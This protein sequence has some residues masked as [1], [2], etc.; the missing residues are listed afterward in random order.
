MACVILL[1]IS[2]AI[3]VLVRTLCSITVPHIHYCVFLRRRIWPMEK[4]CVNISR[5]YQLLC[6]SFEPF[7]MHSKSMWKDEFL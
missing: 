1:L 4:I 3:L 6:L 7:H 2:G 5:K